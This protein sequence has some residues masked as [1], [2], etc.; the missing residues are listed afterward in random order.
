VPVG[1]P[2]FEFPALTYFSERASNRIPYMTLFPVGKRMRA[3]LF[4]YREADD[5][6]LREMRRKPVETLNAPLPR[7][8]RITGEFDI[9]G[10]IKIRPADIYVSTGYRQAGIVLAIRTEPKLR[11]Q[12][13]SSSS[14]SSFLS[15][16]A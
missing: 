6:W 5:P 12:S 13:P 15:S 7:L 1:R 14:S 8:R 11:A 10:D 9:S 4:A 3:N 16:S 2:F